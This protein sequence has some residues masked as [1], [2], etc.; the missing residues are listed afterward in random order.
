MGKPIR[1]GAL[2]EAMSVATFAWAQTGDIRPTVALVHG[3]AWDGQML[4]LAQ[5][6]FWVVAHARRGHGR[7]SHATH[8]DQINADLLAFISNHDRASSAI[9]RRCQ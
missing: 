7:S 6:G 5:N 4:L 1:A 2:T 8:Q 9:P 3:T